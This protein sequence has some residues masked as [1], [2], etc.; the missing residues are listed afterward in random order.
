[1][2]ERGLYFIANDATYDLAVALLNSVRTFE[3]LMPIC[4]IPY[5]RNYGRILALKSIYQFSLWED[6]AALCWC[7]EIGERF[8]GATL[9]QYR[10]LAMWNGPFQEFAYLDVDT[11]LLSGLDVSFSLLKD[12]DIVTGTSDSAASRS[13][14]W[15]DTL[16]EV[17]FDSAYAA[18]TG[19]LFSKRNIV[20]CDDVTRSV[21]AALPYAAHMELMCA[22]Q[23]F[24]NYLIVT[25]G[26]RYSSLKRIARET[27][28]KD[29][30][31]HVWSGRFDGDLLN[32]KSPA[33][34]IHWA[35]EWQRGA[36]LRSPV[37][38]HFRHLRSDCR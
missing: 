38:N 36:H 15:K 3:P 10:K 1:M 19:V 34:V 8:H 16:P 17:S 25:S 7:D 32:L 37:W 11:V 27:N 13:F 18:N 14:V 5:N 22:E 35:G 20:S 24:L 21:E 28:R 6:Q 33:L 29:L 23:A 26:L 2:N 4:L 30:P 31:Q 9:G 12:Y